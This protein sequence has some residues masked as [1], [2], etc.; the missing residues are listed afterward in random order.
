[1]TVKAKFRCTS[2]T[3]YGHVTTVKLQAVY[4]DLNE[5]KDF[6]KATPW[7]VLEMNIDNGVPASGFF[8]PLKDYYFDFSKVEPVLVAPH[9]PEPNHPVFVPD[10]ESLHFSNW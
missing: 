10:G 6:T 8:E 3:N 1:M 9:Q 2:V 4:S 7:G 5:N